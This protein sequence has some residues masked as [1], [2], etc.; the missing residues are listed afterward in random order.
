MRLTTSST[1]DEGRF[2]IIYK[3]K[4]L[5]SRTDDASRQEAIDKGANVVK[6]IT[7]I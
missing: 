7:D 1:K 4:L 3:I 5:R 2:W 6:Y